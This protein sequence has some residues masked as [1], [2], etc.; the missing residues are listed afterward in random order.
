MPPLVM[1]LSPSFYTACRR[2]LDTM[3][4]GSVTVMVPL[5]STVRC[6]R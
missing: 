6:R 2:Q 4:S 5:L 1:A 3:D